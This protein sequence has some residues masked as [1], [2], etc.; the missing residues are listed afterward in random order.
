M[1]AKQTPST[2]IGL[3]FLV[4]G[5]SPLDTYFAIILLFIMATIVHGI[6]YVEMKL[7]P[8]DIEYLPILRFVCLVFGIIAIELLVTIIISPF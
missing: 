3:H 1:Q 2:I 8:Q 7:L 4:L 5:I 6:A